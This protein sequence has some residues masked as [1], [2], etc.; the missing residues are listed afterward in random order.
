MCACVRV[1]E[2]VSPGIV[3]VAR[4]VEWAKLWDSCLSLG[5]AVPM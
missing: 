4:E 1:E 5:R 3:E 2:M